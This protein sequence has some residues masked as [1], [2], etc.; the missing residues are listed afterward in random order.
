MRVPT[1]CISVVSLA[2]LPFAAACG[3][4]SNTHGNPE[5]GADGGHSQEGGHHAEGGHPDGGHTDGGKHHEAGADTGESDS[6]CGSDVVPARVTTDLTLTLACSPWHVHKSVQV[7]GSSAPVLTIE[8]G[9]TVLFDKGTH[10]EVGDSMP[11]TLQ[12]VGTKS[13]P[14]MLTSSAT[15]PKAGDWGNIWL[16]SHADQS[17][18]MQY[19][20]VD[21]AGATVSPLL[22]VPTD[23]GAII[24]DGGMT[25]AFQILLQ[26]VTVSH[27]SSSG[28]VFFGHLT[29]FAPSS[30]PLTITDWASGGYPI[31]IDGNDAETLPTS[32]TTGATGTEGAIGIIQQ[33]ENVNGGG[34][35]LIDHTQTWPA[36]P[37]PYAIDSYG[38]GTAGQCGLMID[39]TGT[40]VATLTIASPNEIHF[41][42]TAA[43]P[44][45]CG[46]YVDYNNLGQGLLIAAGTALTKKDSIAFTSGKTPQ[47]AGDWLGIQFGHS[48][49][50]QGGS[51][52]A[53][54]TLS[55][56]VGPTT[57][58]TPEGAVVVDMYLGA[59]TG[60]SITNCAF[61]DYVPTPAFTYGS[62][63]I[64]TR[65]VS[66][67]GV[68]GTMSAGAGGNTFT[69]HG[70][71]LG[72]VCTF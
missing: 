50:G 10:L 39:G 49:G 19:V 42:P 67:P 62:C 71:A 31:V 70:S 5:G 1:V 72:D 37:I 3:S 36:M 21:Y 58:I 63:G 4:S 13:L 7:G 35:T 2:I 28:I 34:Q 51:Q 59:S 45:P 48:A 23:D 6:G 66:P 12:A 40:S 69:P 47:A 25:N 29:G 53:Y 27:T 55:F 46:I 44:A 61:D 60:P 52:L 9:V 14:I 43:F 11:G 41:V 68:Y 38:S 64:T 26:N 8:P 32:I 57:D 54:C 24:I 22:D 15:T 17:S 56:A 16:A 65:D 30:G 20:T 33:W 18:T